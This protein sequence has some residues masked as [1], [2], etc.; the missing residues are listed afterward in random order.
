MFFTMYKYRLKHLF[1]EKSVV[2]WL[3]LYPLI[4]A[5]I[6][7]LSFSNLLT[8]EV[9][10]KINIAII[11]DSIIT[12]DINKSM[13]ESQLFN[14]KFATMDECKKLLENSNVDAYI[15]TDSTTGSCEL[16]F[17]KTGPNQSITKIFFDSYTQ[18]SA[19]IR[20]VIKN[21]GAKSPKDIFSKIDINKNHIENIPVNSSNNIVVIFFYSLF[22]MTSF[23]SITLGIDVANEIQANQSDLACRLSTVPVSKFKVLVS[24]LAGS[25]T[26][27][28]ISIILNLFYINTILQIDFGNQLGLVFLISVIGSFCGIAVGCFIGAIIVK[29]D[30]I[31]MG[32]AIGFTIFCSFLSGMMNVE[33][34]YS[35]SRNFPTLSK[36][37]PV[38]L[39]TDGLYSLYYYNSLDRYLSNVFLLIIISLVFTFMSLL[40][41]RRQKYES[42]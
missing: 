26:F 10:E 6:Y 17:K 34:K 4:M 23:F 16:F 1:R 5:T 15:K 7:N 29:K 36:L 37:N 12:T 11:S 21:V 19:S 8:G 40:L 35:F 2:F 33:I 39:I 3:L 14:I 41:L 31:K 27:H 32:I 22:A 25:L 13:E 38:G 24:T 18:M 42:I 30:G 20:N 9:F 28:I